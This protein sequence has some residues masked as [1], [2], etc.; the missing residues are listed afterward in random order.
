MIK[1]SSYLPKNHPYLNIKLGGV[2]EDLYIR[3]SYLEGLIGVREYSI[4]RNPRKVFQEALSYLLDS[5]AQVSNTAQLIVE[6]LQDKR[7]SEDDIAILVGMKDT[8]LRES[9]LK[10]AEKAVAQSLHGSGSA[11]VQSEEVVQALSAG[12]NPVTVEP[13]RRFQ[14]HGLFYFSGKKAQDLPSLSLSS[15]RAFIMKVSYNLTQEILVGSKR[16]DSVSMQKRVDEVSTGSHSEGQTSG[17][18][19]SAINQIRDNMSEVDVA[20]A[21]G[22]LLEDPDT[23]K[24]IDRTV[25]ARLGGQAQQEVWTAV[26]QNPDLIQVRGD[27]IGIDQ[28][29]LLKAL[30]EM[31]GKVISR[32]VAGRTFREDVLPAMR[33]ALKNSRILQDFMDSLAFQQTYRSDVNRYASK[34]PGEKPTKK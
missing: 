5:S 3:A 17:E 20:D 15:I 31:T 12:L 13:I 2:S 18:G 27:N 28:E 22:A 24:E 11:R 25:R 26:L 29:G 4:S 34:K 30:T 14:G 21:M 23:L 16:L 1:I 32:Q 10:A 33:R 8:R 6:T 9:M 19:P 7:V